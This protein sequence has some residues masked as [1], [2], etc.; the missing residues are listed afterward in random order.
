MFICHIRLSDR[1]Q[2]GLHQQGNSKLNVLHALQMCCT[3][4]M[5][6]NPKT[7]F[8]MQ[9]MFLLQDMFTKLAKPPKKHLHKYYGI[10]S[11]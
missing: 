4:F 6:K 7:K 8:L 2:T 9:D 10:I 5:Q 11:T 1:H 3:I